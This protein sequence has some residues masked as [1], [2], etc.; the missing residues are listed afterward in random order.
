M[1]LY[2]S[3]SLICF[4]LFLYMSHVEVEYFASN[5]EVEIL[6]QP[7]LANEFLKGQGVHHC[8]PELETLLQWTCLTLKFFGNC[9][10]YIKS[11]ESMLSIA[12]ISRQ[13]N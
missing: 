3:I 8:I 7:F 12:N 6:F 9:T 5:L 10:I 11:A 1:I 13:R 4:I 2:V